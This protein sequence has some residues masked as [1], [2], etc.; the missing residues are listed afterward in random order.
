[1][2]SN[3]KSAHSL[4]HFFSQQKQA[5]SCKE[6]SQHCSILSYHANNS[7]LRYPS[8]YTPFWKI[9]GTLKQSRHS[10]ERRAHNLSVVRFGVPCILSELSGTVVEVLRNAWDVLTR[11]TTDDCWKDCLLNSPQPMRAL[12]VPVMC[13]A[14]QN[15][16]HWALSTNPHRSNLI[17]SQPDYS[18]LSLDFNRL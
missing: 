3:Q 11:E 4:S 14:G 12:F 16:F 17:V 2:R 13:D 18:I 8:L 1:M 5:Q 15:A 9:D 6:H 10:K 7:I